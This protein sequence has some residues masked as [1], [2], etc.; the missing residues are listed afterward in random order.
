MALL[1]IAAGVA[2][3]IGQWFLIMA[4]RQGDASVIAPFSYTQLIWAGLLGFWVFGTVP[5][6][7]TILGGGIIAASG[8]YTAYRARVR[9]LEKRF[10][11]A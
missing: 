7:W 11:N 6:A 3:T 2:F 8:L 1:G 9:A 10:K 4:Y 5:N